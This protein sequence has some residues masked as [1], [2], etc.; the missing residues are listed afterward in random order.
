MGLA[1]N[2]E[3]P[4]QRLYVD[5]LGPYPRSKA[6]NTTILIILDHLTKFVWLK[7]LRVATANAI[8]RFIES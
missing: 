3:R 7:P 6:K 2:S 5:L 8:T 1:Y 4:F